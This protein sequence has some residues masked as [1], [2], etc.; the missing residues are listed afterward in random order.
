MISFLKTKLLIAFGVLLSNLA[1]GQNFSAFNTTQCIS[2]CF[3]IHQN[4]TFCNYGREY[5]IC[6]APDDNNNTLCQ[7]NP[8]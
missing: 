8:S 2:Q 4:A 5:G 7:S 1:R 6:C 3:N